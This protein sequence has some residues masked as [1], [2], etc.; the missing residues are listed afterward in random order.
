MGVVFN[1]EVT[2]AFGPVPL[3][4]HTGVLCALPVY[5]DFI[6]FFKEIAEMEVVALSNIFYAKIVNNERE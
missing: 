3:K 5:V 4:S 1:G 2:G 6:V